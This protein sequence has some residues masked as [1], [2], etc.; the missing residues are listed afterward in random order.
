[1]SILA[2]AIF[3]GMPP[4]APPLSPLARALAAGGWEHAWRTATTPWEAGRPNPYLARHLL[5]Q[6]SPLGAPRRVL[7]PGCGSGHDALALAAAGHA[8][9][10][11]DISPSAL[12]AAAATAA[13][14]PPAARERLTLLEADFFA[15]RS[16]LHG[17]F[18]AVWDYTFCAAL[19][20]ALRGAWAEATRRHLRAGGALH[21]ALFP[22][23]APGGGA[24]E[25]E[26][27]G[28]PFAQHPPDIDALLQRSGF[29]PARALHAIPAAL[30]F[31]ARAGREWYGEW[32]A[33]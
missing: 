22:V 13:A 18:D 26:G 12:A 2:Q 30:S 28:P 23:A 25:P 5:A 16:P 15:A 1:M 8:V 17:A 20:L 19:P 33:A 6:P 32:L 21:L 9:T 24:A 14:A 4:P 27:G 10:G 11:L 7:V 3:L 29:A 31:K